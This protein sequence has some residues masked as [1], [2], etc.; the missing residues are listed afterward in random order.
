MKQHQLVSG[1]GSA[2]I[3]LP[4]ILSTKGLSLGNLR[5]SSLSFGNDDPSAGSMYF[6]TRD[7]LNDSLTKSSSDSGM[8]DLVSA[9]SAVVGSLFHE[10][11]KKKTTIVQE[12]KD[13]AP[14]KK[15]LTDPSTFIK[16]L[17]SIKNPVQISA[18]KAIPAEIPKPLESKKAEIIK[19]ITDANVIDKRSVDLTNPERPSSE[20]RDLPQS[21]ATTASYGQQQKNEDHRQQKSTGTM[22]SNALLDVKDVVLYGP[23]IVSAWKSA[24]LSGGDKLESAYNIMSIIFKGKDAWD[25]LSQSAGSLGE[26]ISVINSS[27]SE[28]VMGNIIK[29]APAALGMAWWTVV[30]ASIAV[31]AISAIKGW[32]WNGARLA[33]VDRN[34]SE[35][36]E[37]YKK[38]V[39][40]A[41]KNGTP[42]RNLTFNI[43]I[44]G[45]N[46]DIHIL[47]DSS[48]TYVFDTRSMLCQQLLEFTKHFA[49]VKADLNAAKGE[50]EKK[51]KAITGDENPIFFIENRLL[52]VMNG[53]LSLLN[54]VSDV[55]ADMWAN[56][57]LDQSHDLNKNPSDVVKDYEGIEQKKKKKK[58][59]KT[60]NKKPTMTSGSKDNTDVSIDNA[61]IIWQYNSEK[62][63]N[64]MKIYDKNTK[65]EITDEK[66]LD[67]FE[68]EAKR[69]MEI[70]QKN[71]EDMKPPNPADRAA[72][73]LMVKIDSDL[74]NVAKML[75]EHAFDLP[76]NLTGVKSEDIQS[77]YSRLLNAEDSIMILC[78]RVM[79]YSTEK[80]SQPSSIGSGPSMRF[81]RGVSD[82]CDPIVVKNLLDEIKKVASKAI[83]SS[84]SQKKTNA[85]S[86]LVQIRDSFDDETLIMKGNMPKN[87]KPICLEVFQ[88]SLDTITNVCQLRAYHA[89]KSMKMISEELSNLENS[90]VENT[91]NAVHKF[92][93]EVT[94]FADPEP[95]NP[96]N[97]EIASRVTIPGISVVASGVL[98]Y[99]NQMSGKDQELFDF[100]ESVSAVYSHYSNKVGSS[101]ATTRKWNDEITQ[102][103]KDTKKPSQLLLVMSSVYTFLSRVH[104]VRLSKQRIWRVPYVI[105]NDLFITFMAKRFHILDRMLLLLEADALITRIIKVSQHHKAPYVRLGYAMF[106]I[107]S[108]TQTINS[109]TASMI[110]SADEFARAS[111]GR[112]NMTYYTE[113]VVPEM[114]SS[115]M[116]AVYGPPP[117]PGN[118]TGDQGKRR[119]EYMTTAQVLVDNLSTTTAFNI[120]ATILTLLSLPPWERPRLRFH[121][122]EMFTNWYLMSCIAEGTLD[123][124]LNVLRF[125]CIDM[126]S[127]ST[128]K[129]ATN[130]IVTFLDTALPLL[131][132]IREYLKGDDQF[133]GMLN[134]ARTLNRMYPWFILAA[135][136]VVLAAVMHES[137]KK[138]AKV[139]KQDNASIV[140]DDWLAQEIKFIGKL[141]EESIPMAESN[142][143]ESPQNRFYT[144]NVTNVYLETSCDSIINILENTL[145]GIYDVDKLCFVGDHGENIKKEGTP[146]GYCEGNDPDMLASRIVNGFWAIEKLPEVEDS[147]GFVLERYMNLLSTVKIGTDT[148]AVP[149]NDNKERMKKVNED[150]NIAMFT[151]IANDLA[152][153]KKIGFLFAQYDPK[154]K[155]K[156]MSKV[157]VE[158]KRMFAMLNH[159]CESKKMI[160]ENITK[161][162]RISICLAALAHVLYYVTDAL[163]FHEAKKKAE[164][165]DVSGAYYSMAKSKWYSFTSKS[166]LATHAHHYRMIT[167]HK[168]FDYVVPS[169]TGG[170]KDAKG[171]Y[172]SLVEGAYKMLTIAGFN[173]LFSI[174]NRTNEFVS[175]KKAIFVSHMTEQLAKS[176]VSFTG[177]KHLL[178]KKAFRFCPADFI[179]PDYYGSMIPFDKFSF[180]RD[181][182]T[183]Q[184]IS[185]LA[186]ELFVVMKQ[187]CEDKVE[188]CANLKYKF[189]GSVWVKYGASN[190]KNDILTLTDTFEEMNILYRAK[191]VFSLYK[192]IVEKN[193]SYYNETSIPGNV[194][195]GTLQIID[196]IVKNN[197][198]GDPTKGTLFNSKNKKSNPGVKFDANGRITGID[199]IRS[200][201][202]SFLLCPNPFVVWDDTVESV[203]G[204]LYRLMYPKATMPS[205]S[206]DSASFS[207][208]RKAAGSDIPIGDDLIDENH[209]PSDMI[210]VWCSGFT[211]GYASE[212]TKSISEEQY[213]DDLI[214]GSKAERSLMTQTKDV[215]LA[216]AAV[217]NAVIRF[218]AI[219]ESLPS[220]APATRPSAK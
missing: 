181:P 164:D 73:S 80:I 141:V 177:M 13:T 86:F 88:A 58:D 90:A 57:I 70:K 190:K 11:V 50:L 217:A 144:A 179:K 55:A 93:S 121:R 75:K 170:S 129:A 216:V 41:A 10:P 162:K 59:D 33:A 186:L 155:H 184:A 151:D 200:Q 60:T 207:R 69:E 56:T 208:N 74:A 152:S 117:L 125:I 191:H 48:V 36:K 134:S 5:Q 118:D 105:D 142:T 198:V 95:W 52:V 203:Y 103:M 92:K 182:F 38:K 187:I 126:G 44:S 98:K 96:F 61:L 24:G 156:G 213:I 87:K 27:V 102:E 26:M 6:K 220:K 139:I 159:V 94:K 148:V 8:G 169:I 111:N 183:W 185:L 174:T 104:S 66:I 140:E 67:K 132:P 79:E 77:H 82:K 17:E 49:S 29:L 76:S 133:R 35:L 123:S 37:S 7:V 15:E 127:L 196:E 173:T 154:A 158:V 212:T 211:F 204:R 189:T 3:V 178:D 71:N 22:A 84:L 136:C 89:D 100:C 195:L 215:N 180:P 39:D 176:L 51:M 214:F 63:E 78:T 161:L 97:W 165:R 68:K 12:T 115:A 14:T 85:E 108:H 199:D 101:S 166:V 201:F 83:R 30:V 205:T 209:S 124:A 54:S 112:M 28:G 4:E 31:S 218:S 146:L 1:R 45:N 81:L 153:N 149:G 150:M 64:E 171:T 145:H 106:Y 175:G 147:F 23:E 53:M 137:N 188:L 120:D 34:A 32:F 130:A 72:L 116:H 172:R 43:N 131:K 42:A 138:K 40:D 113:K 206:L 20:I 16:I 99:K 114:V 219:L 122:G 2:T 109:E 119:A 19:V 193:A 192:E 9:L 47:V 163:L 46:N 65:K 110:A 18:D 167:E 128:T 197:G 62:K 25:R 21:T 143:A 202:L 135:E 194:F 157:E 210:A 91:V 168:L 107:K 160:K